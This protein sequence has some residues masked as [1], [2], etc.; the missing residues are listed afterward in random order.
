MSEA[1]ARLMSARQ[2]LVTV[3][4]LNEAAKQTALSTGLFL[5]KK[6]GSVVLVSNRPGIPPCGE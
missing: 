2:R 5:H 6:A 3:A 1:D 4:A